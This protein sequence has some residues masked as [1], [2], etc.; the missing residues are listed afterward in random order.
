VGIA[1]CN[2]VNEPVNR[3]I[4]VLPDFKALGRALSACHVL[5]EKQRSAAYVTE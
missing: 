4:V 2:Q 3:T 1:A 5:E